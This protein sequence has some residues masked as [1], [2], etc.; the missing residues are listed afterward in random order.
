[1]N[2]KNNG[3]NK[4]VKRVVISVGSIL[5]I[6]LVAASI[7]W[8]SIPKGQRNMLT[9][10]MFSGGNYDNY[11]VSQVVDRNEIDFKPTTFIPVPAETDETNNNQNIL[12]VTEMLQ[13]ESSSMLKGAYVQDLGINDYNGWHFLA[14]EGAAEGENPYGPSPIKLLYCRCSNKLTYPNY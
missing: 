14:D 9:F 6:A 1:M 11:E 8:F 2:K 10:M 5:L 12:V 7:Y 3:K 4:V 13:N